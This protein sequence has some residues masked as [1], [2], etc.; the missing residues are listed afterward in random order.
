[1]KNNTIQKIREFNNYIKGLYKDG[2][3]TKNTV[4][5]IEYLTGNTGITFK[6][7]IQHSKE[8]FVLTYDLIS[9]IYNENGFYNNGFSCIK[10]NGKPSIDLSS[11][12][13][14]IPFVC[15]TQ[16]QGNTIK[17]LKI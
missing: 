10:I 15:Y 9:D 16:I 6:I 1:M 4:K 12:V 5:D 7:K 3:D 13:E 14:E 17:E 11:L 2:D 8:D